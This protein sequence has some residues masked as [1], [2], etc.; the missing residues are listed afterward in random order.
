MHQPSMPLFAWILFFVRVVPQERGRDGLMPKV[1]W[2]LLQGLEVQQLPGSDR[3]RARRVPLQGRL[4]QQ[5]RRDLPQVQRRLQGGRG[6]GEFQ[7]RRV[8]WTAG[9]GAH[10]AVLQRRRLALAQHHA[11]RVE[12]PDGPGAHGPRGRHQLRLRRKLGVL[13]LHVRQDGPG[14]AAGRLDD[15]VGAHHARAGPDSPAPGR[16][17]H[18]QCHQGG[19]GPLPGHKLQRS[20]DQD[21]C[22]GA[23]QAVWTGRYGDVH[24]RQRRERR[25]D[26]ARQ[27]AAAPRPVPRAAD[28]APPDARHVGHAPRS[29][30]PHGRRLQR[31]LAADVARLDG[32][33]VL[34]GQP[35]GVLRVHRARAGEES[36][37]GRHGRGRR[38]GRVLRLRRAGAGAAERGQWDHAGGAPGALQPRQ[39]G[40]HQQRCLCGA[41]VA[42]SLLQRHGRQAGAQGRLLARDV[43]QLSGHTGGDAVRAGRRRQPGERRAPADAAAGSAAHCVVRQHRR[44]PERQRGLLLGRL[45]GPGRGHGGPGHGPALRQVRVP[46]RL[47]RHAEQLPRQQPGVRDGGVLRPRLRASGG[48]GRRQAGGGAEEPPRAAEPLVGDRRRLRGGLACRVQRQKL[49]LCSSLA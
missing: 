21:L 48:A 23:P 43:G 36:A 6:A 22:G 8:P 45:R 4:L 33:S 18:Q 17:R 32:L 15:P 29:G 41:H 46:R 37:P 39:G 30:G 49:R 28:R 42:G 12:G 10:S 27:P 19:H 9:R 7:V 2:R 26:R 25:G 38:S 13:H 5:R 47:P 3:V 44:G 11:G 35:E 34:P 40:G 31:R 1:Y 24:G 16:D 14:G 20:V